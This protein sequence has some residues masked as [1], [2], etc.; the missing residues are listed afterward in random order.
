MN[1]VVSGASAS[2][3]FAPALESIDEPERVEHRE[4]GEPSALD[5]AQ[6]RGAGGHH[7]LEDHDRCAGR[8]LRA[9]DPLVRTVAL[10]LLAHDE[11]GARLTCLKAQD[12]GRGREWIGAQGEATD[13]DRGRRD[14]VDREVE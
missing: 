9:L 14:L 5:R 7:V 3:G 10:G 8:K 1:R 2:D 13:R 11:G 4:A 12:A 6:G